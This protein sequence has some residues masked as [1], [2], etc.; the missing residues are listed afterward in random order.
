MW[1]ELSPEAAKARRQG[2]AR[3]RLWDMRLSPRLARTANLAVI[4]RPEYGGRKRQADLAQWIRTRLPQ[5]QFDASLNRWEAPLSELAAA[6]AVLRL[7]GM[8]EANV[9]PGVRQMLDPAS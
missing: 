7:A 4:L 1:T 9:S 8:P 5:F 3:A 6:A 2:Q